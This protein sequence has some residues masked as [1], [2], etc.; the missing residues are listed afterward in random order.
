MTHNA[1]A[2]ASWAN[3]D[4]PT[5][6]EITVMDE[7]GATAVNGD[8]GGTWAPASKIEIGGEG[9]SARHIYGLIVVGADANTTY[10]VSAARLIYLDATITA[11]RTYALGDSGADIGDVMEIVVLPAFSTARTVTIA[12]NFGTTIASMGRL[13]AAGTSRSAKFVFLGTQWRLL[14]SEKNSVAVVN[15]GGV[16]SISAQN[17]LS[18]TIADIPGYTASL[19]CVAGDVLIV[20]MVLAFSMDD[21]NACTLTASVVDGGVTTDVAS[22][23]FRV[24]D[25]FNFERIWAYTVRYVVVNTGTVTWKGRY[26]VGTGDTLSVGGSSAIGTITL[27]QLRA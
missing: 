11:D 22:A 9:L 10:T 12:D 24:L 26:L 13:A 2:R 5:A 6:A 20:N 17:L 15:V 1:L 18:E 14:S 8:D 16:G 19:S 4:V 21:D 23:G 7:N 27:L 25:A 3:L